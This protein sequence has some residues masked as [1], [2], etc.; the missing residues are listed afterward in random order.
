M[1]LYKTITVDQHTKVL[2]WKV[3]E[4]IEWL[5]KGIELT[6]NCQARANGMKSE[7]HKRG[8]LSIRHLLAEAG[9]TDF[10]LY[11]DELGK[12]H[13]KDDKYISITHSF[14][15][16]AIIVGEE[17]VGIDIEKRR[18]KILKIAEKFTPIEE[19]KT[20]ANVAA[21]IRKLTI[22][23]GAKESIYKIYPEPGLSFLQ[24]INIADFDFDDAKTTG[25]VYFNGRTSNFEL[26]FL[27]FEGYTCVYAKRSAEVNAN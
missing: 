23:W 3:E 20:L 15:F 9:Y 4:T 17:Q 5:S 6:L 12:P 24:H 1:A 14:E 25:K 8:F 13:L 10:D 19:Y 22:V 18:D 16:T 2:I 21:L 27:E 7:L 26:Q 11:Y